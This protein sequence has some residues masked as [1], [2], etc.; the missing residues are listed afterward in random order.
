MKKLSVIGVLLLIVFVGCVQ[1]VST[2]NIDDYKTVPK[3]VYT[4][5]LYSSGI[6]ERLRAVFLKS[7]ETDVEIVPYSRQITTA[8]VTFSDALTFMEKVGDYKNIS[9]Q[10]VKY[11]EKTIGYLLT[12]ARP[13]SPRESIEADVYE[14]DGKIYFAVKEKRYDE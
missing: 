11:K 14:R 10:G 6:G 2:Y 7:P 12:F 9:I 8:K 1:A 3:V 5:Y 4:A 13:L